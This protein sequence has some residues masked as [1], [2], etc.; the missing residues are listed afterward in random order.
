[1]GRILSVSYD[2]SLLYTRQLILEQHGYDV[3]SALGFT[4][5]L[6]CCD[7]A[8]DFSIF[9]LG[10]SIP[11]EDKEALIAAFR[12]HCSGTVVALKRYNEGPVAGADFETEPS[13]EAILEVLEQIHSTKHMAAD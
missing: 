2:Q 7:Q 10:H 4:Q 3:V 1:M 11:R 13:P 8:K 12:G 9:I 6:K 5:A